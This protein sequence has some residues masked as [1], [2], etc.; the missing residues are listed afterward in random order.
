MGL[1]IRAFKITYTMYDQNAAPRQMY[2]VN[3]TCSSCGTAITQLPFMPSGDKPLLCRDCLR[4]KKSAGFNNRGPRPM[5][6]MFDVD[7]NCSECG[8]HI[9]QLPF[10]PTNGKPVYCFDCNKARRDNMA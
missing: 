8:K 7:I 10:Q 2:D 1:Q 4:A 3:E 6:Q 5:K 9:S